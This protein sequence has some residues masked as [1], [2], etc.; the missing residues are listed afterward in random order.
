[1]LL[2]F[3][4]VWSGDGWLELVFLDTAL[5]SSAPERLNYTRSPLGPWRT[6][7]VTNNHAFSNHSL[8]LFVLPVWPFFDDFFRRSKKRQKV[9]ERRRRERIETNKRRRKLCWNK[10]Q[11]GF[12]LASERVKRTTAS[13][14]FSPQAFF[15]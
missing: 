13:A 10:H 4:V 1:M 3:K 15:H 9:V 6:P 2:A 11:M 7:Q 12:S 14:Y 8:A 5:D